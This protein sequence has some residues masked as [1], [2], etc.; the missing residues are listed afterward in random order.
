MSSKSSRERM[1][2]EPRQKKKRANKQPPVQSQKEPIKERNT[3]RQKAA[4]MAIPD[5]VSKRM[6]RRMAFFCG[7]PTGLGMSSFFIFYWIVSNEWLKIPASAVGVTSLGLF[8]LGVLGLSYGILSASWDEDR[9]GSWF[10]WGE[11]KSNFGR[12]MTAWQAAREASKKA[13]E[14]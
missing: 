11:F 8:G 9:V 10:G 3:A 5:V 2:F 1:A 13:K 14:N 6:V 7:I 4:S 12:M